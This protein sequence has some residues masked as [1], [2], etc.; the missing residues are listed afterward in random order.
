MLLVTP[1]AAQAR[2]A[3]EARGRL[4][5]QAAYERGLADGEARLSEQLLRQRAEL[6][7]LQNGVLASLR[8]AVPR[9][10]RQSE[11]GVVELALE[12]ARKLVS[13]LPVSAEMVEAAVRSALAQAEEGVSFQVFLAADDLALLQRINSPVLLP[14]PGNEAM[15]F[16]ASAEV[17][18]GGCLVETR[19]GVIDARRET[20][21]KLIRQSLN[22]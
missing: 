6:L 11:A 12:V 14:G 17:T 5:E 21:L 22:A 1:A 13:D 4:S 8:Q 19:F 3:N 15:H 16:Q 7:E 18:R 20:K 10:V 9:V 2:A